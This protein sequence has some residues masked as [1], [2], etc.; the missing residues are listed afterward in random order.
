M[1]TATKTG[2]NVLK[3][4]TK[5]VVYKTA[6][7]IGEFIENKIANKTV[8]PKP[9]PDENLRDVE[10]IIISPEKQNKY[11]A[12]QDKYCKMEHYK[13][14]KLLNDST[15]SKFLTKKWIEVNKLLHAQ[16]SVNKNIR[17]KT[18][19]L[20]SDMW[21]HSDAYIIVKGITIAKGTNN[22]NRRNKKL[23]F[24]NN[25]TFMSWI[26]KINNTFIDKAEDLDAVMPMYNLLKYIDNYIMTSGSLWNYYR[27]QVN[28]N[29]NE[30]NSVCRINYR[31]IT[32]SKSEYEKK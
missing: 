22:V 25:A 9:V 10:E 23:T 16:Y 18:P 11:W 20:R 24:K 4:A 26:S 7:A 6:E 15:V 5:K 31:K 30:K 1:S 2:L 29:V 27:Y 19:M 14:F 3:T 8:Q 12:N 13:I 32:T 17:F 21:D 28:D